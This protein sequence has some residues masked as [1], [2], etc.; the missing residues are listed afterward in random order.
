[1]H[2]PRFN[3][4]HIV[5]AAALTAVAVA[6][7]SHVALAADKL[8]MNVGWSTPVDS[9][10]SVPAKKFKELA[11]EYTAEGQGQPGADAADRESPA[12]A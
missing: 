3:R 4:R 8:V 10:Y 12:V 7:A 1:M 9:S 5:R 6:L 11:E 2:L